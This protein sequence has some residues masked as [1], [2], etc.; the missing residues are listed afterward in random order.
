MKW[1]NELPLQ[2]HGS[3]GR[4]IYTVSLVSKTNIPF[5]FTTAGCLGFDQKNEIL[6]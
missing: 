1:L 6:I 4:N 2:F 5:G 3:L